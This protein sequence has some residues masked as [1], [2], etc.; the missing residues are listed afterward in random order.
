[1]WDKLPE[2]HPSKAVASDYA[3]RYEAQY[4]AG[5][6]SPFGA[7]LYDA[8]RLVEAAVPAALKTA[9][10]G[11]AEFRQSLRD[12]LEGTKDVVGTHG[13]YNLSATDHFGHDQRARA[14]VTVKDQQW[15]L[16]HAPE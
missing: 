16:L 11:S 7:Y 15:V 14:L 10:P 1:V 3:Q 4:G 5:S 13:V 9:Q 8:M 2:T 6:L 12:Q